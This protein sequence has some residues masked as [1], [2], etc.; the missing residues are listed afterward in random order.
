MPSL[1]RKV[2]PWLRR[3]LSGDVGTSL[4]ELVVGMSV[5]TVFMAIFTGAIF[6]MSQT[7]NKVEATTVSSGQTNL[8]FLTLDKT[9]RYAAAI[10]PASTCVSS[11]SA[12]VATPSGDWYVELDSTFSG[13]EVCTQLRVD[14]AAHQ[15]QQRTWTVTATGYT[16]PTSWKALASNVTN[17][18]AVAGPD[19][20]FSV[21]AAVAG[22]SSTFQQLTITLII[23]SGTSTTSTTRSST[24]FTAL[25]SSAAATT[26]ATKCQQAGRP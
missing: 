23:G 15:L 6:S 12:C 3:R 22:A 11:T 14:V 1:M 9:V 8:A 10:T 13:A 25:N 21:P 2:M 19:Q 4:T 7:V 26:N 17:G 16:T 5:M 18:G 20:P 24:S